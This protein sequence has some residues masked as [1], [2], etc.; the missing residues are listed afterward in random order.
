LEA[1]RLLADAARKGGSAQ[2]GAIERALAAGIALNGVGLADRSYLAGGDHNPIGPVAITKIVSGSLMPLTAT[3][4]SP[5][6][7]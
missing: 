3:E 1:V 6:S 4:P 7:P 2:P 5:S